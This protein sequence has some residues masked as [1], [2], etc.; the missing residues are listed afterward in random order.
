MRRICCLLVLSVLLIPS[1]VRA[2]DAGPVRLSLIEGDVQVLIRDAADWTPAA[3]NLPL[4]GRDSLRIL[5]RGRAELQVQDGV[6][7]RTEGDSLLDILAVNRDSI[8]LYLDRGRLYINNLNDGMDL[9]QIDTPLASIT[10]YDNSVLM[11]DVS[12]DGVHEISVLKGE[13]Y[14]ESRAGGTSVRAGNTLTIWGETSAEISPVDTPDAWERWNADR[15][16]KLTDWSES[17]RYLPDELR[18]YSPDFDQYGRWHYSTN[19]GYVW[20]PVL[21]APGW[22]PYSSGSW[23]WIRGNYVWI[24]HDPWGW[25]PSHYGRW[26]FIGS[27][28]WCWVPPAAGAVYWG[29]GYVGWIVTPS[30]VAWVPL[31]PGEI[32][33]GYGFYG[34][35]SVN[36]TTVEINT[37]IVN[38]TYRNASVRKSV[39]A[40]RRDSFGTGRHTP[41]RLRENP[42]VTT[43]APGTVNIAP[44]RIRP[45]RPVAVAPSETRRHAGQ[46]VRRPETRTIV[47]SGRALTVPATKERK[48]TER[49]VGNIRS[50]QAKSTSTPSQLR[51]QA[52]ET[53]RRNRPQELKKER[54]MILKPG[55]S[56]GKP[57]QQKAPKVTRSGKKRGIS[58]GDE[59]KKQ[60][61]VQRRSPQR[62]PEQHQK[63]YGSSNI[64]Q[65]AARVEKREERR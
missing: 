23:N 3:I 26:V 42:F 12:V 48:G 53:I 34:P 60:A 57:Q 9:V 21:I 47:R 46:T 22:A 13:A 27:F 49:G 41:V 8:R 7:A 35:A 40:V 65:P 15:D 39:V 52:P 63:Q 32:Y 17:S 43:A 14:A 58:G 25:A 5:D 38:R 62:Q 11:I 50:L 19:Y 1:I 2:E 16:R 33:Y 37:V 44:P 30:Y 61:A 54:S 51:Q 56:V 18:G 24:D 29:P 36:I 4:N 10:G 59:Q 64:K 20:S 45:K 31:A 28:G 6:Y 55:T